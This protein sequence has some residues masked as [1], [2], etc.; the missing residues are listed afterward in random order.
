MVVDVPDIITCT[1]F[2]DRRLRGF[3]VAGVKFP[4]PDRLSSSPLQHS[5][6]TVR[7]CD[8]VERSTLMTTKERVVLASA[9]FLYTSCNQEALL[10]QTDCTTRYSNQ[11]L[12]KCCTIVGTRSTTNPYEIEVM[13]LEHCSR[14][15]CSLLCGSSHTSAVISVVNKLERP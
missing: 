7:V 14:R 9:H 6:T 10:L 5:R 13:Q 4:P 11:N 12:V 3:W 2:G 1:N 15:T 8:D